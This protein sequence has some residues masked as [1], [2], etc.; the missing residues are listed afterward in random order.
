MNKRK[1]LAEMTPWER[2]EQRL[3]GLT[4]EEVEDVAL[5]ILAQLMAK[6]IHVFED[7]KEYFHGFLEKLAEETVKYEREHSMELAMGAVFRDREK[8]G[9]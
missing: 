9:N 1:K 3:R 2:V 6:H 7:G 8:N 4:N 5:K